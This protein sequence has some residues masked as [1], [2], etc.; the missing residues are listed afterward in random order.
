M[1]NVGQVFNLSGQD[2]ILSYH[3]AY[4]IADPSLLEGSLRMTQSRDFQLK[5]P[6]NSPKQLNAWKFRK[7]LLQ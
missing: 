3:H 6:E 2:E 7:D 5:L 1:M 4:R